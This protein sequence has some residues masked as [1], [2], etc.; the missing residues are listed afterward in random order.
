MHFDRRNIV[1]QILFITAAVI[2]AATA[3]P[4]VTLQQMSLDD[5]TE[6]STSIVRAR[7]NG[8]AASTTG[9]T[10]YTHYKLQV[11]ETLKGKPV[12]DVA[13]PG[14]VSA[15]YRQSFPGVPQLASGSEYV[16]FLWISPQGVTQVIGMTQGIFTIS[17]T[18]GSSQAGRA[19]SS[20]TMHD[21][22]GRVVQDRAVEMSLSELK[23]RIFKKLGQSANR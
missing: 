12:T 4:A 15:G 11:L 8:S 21:A 22:A 2:A 13:L 1:R 20:E 9:R 3:A 19:Q 5:M 23:D 18:A 10:I 6:A 16:L 17:G 14:G 7:V